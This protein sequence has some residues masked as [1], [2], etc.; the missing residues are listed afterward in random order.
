MYPWLT[1]ETVGAAAVSADLRR[2][3]APSTAAPG[4][5]ALQFAGQEPALDIGLR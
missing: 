2:I 4:K 3:G 1:L 5:I